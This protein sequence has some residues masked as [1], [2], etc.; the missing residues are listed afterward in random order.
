M[1]F[2]WVFFYVTL[3]FLYL[4]NVIFKN[5]PSL[6]KEKQSRIQRILNPALY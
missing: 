2:S 3:L 5:H 1:F 6:N 4:G